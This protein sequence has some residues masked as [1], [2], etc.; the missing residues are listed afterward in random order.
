MLSLISFT[1][2]LSRKVQAKRQSAATVK[3]ARLAIC[4]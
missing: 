4:A 3:P 2:A 1:S